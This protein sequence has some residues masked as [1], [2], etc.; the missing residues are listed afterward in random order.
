VC[1]SLNA[2]IP[3]FSRSLPV[4]GV[5]PACG[6]YKTRQDKGGAVSPAFLVVETAP[7]HSGFGPAATHTPTQPRRSAEGALFYPCFR[8]T[9]L[10]SRAQEGAPPPPAPQGRQGTW[11][12]RVRGC[13]PG[14]SGYLRG[15]TPAPQGRRRPEAS[16]AGPPEAY[17]FLR[18][19]E[20]RMSRLWSLKSVLD[21]LR[22]HAAQYKTRPSQAEHAAGRA[23]PA[24]ARGASQL[25]APGS[26]RTAG[27]PVPGAGTPGSIAELQGA[28]WA[29]MY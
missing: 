29:E 13:A 7:P 4:R 19:A 16:S 22:V 11:N 5:R 20:I 23:G 6:V 15:R 21:A 28:G 18:G 3:P 17:I 1:W 12:R 10:Q 2:G 9:A 25:L 14:T 26:W 27:S 8:P 24:E